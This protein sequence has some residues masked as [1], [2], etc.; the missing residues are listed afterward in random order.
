TLLRRSGGKRVLA[1]MSGAPFLNP[2]RIHDP[3]PQTLVRTR[4]TVTW[5]FVEAHRIR[6][7]RLIPKKWNY[8]VI[9]AVAV[10]PSGIS[11]GLL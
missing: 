4:V 1:T 11:H 7:Q 6:K 10:G 2:K 5:R 9:R 3:A 8:S